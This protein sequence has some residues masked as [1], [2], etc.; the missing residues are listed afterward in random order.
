MNINSLQGKSTKNPSRAWPGGVRSQSIQRTVKVK[1]QTEGG[2]ELQRP[3]TCK[4]LWYVYVALP[5]EEEMCRRFFTGS[6]KDLGKES[7]V[8]YD[9]ASM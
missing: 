3:R 4:Q 1:T 9:Y 7:V 8:L 5:L 2:P 6:H